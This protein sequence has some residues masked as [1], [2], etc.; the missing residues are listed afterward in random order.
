MF[1]VCRAGELANPTIERVKPMPR[2]IVLEVSHN[3]SACERRTVKSELEP[4]Y[5]AGARCT[6]GE[7]LP[8]AI[9]RGRGQPLALYHEDRLVDV[10]A[11]GRRLRD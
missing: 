5:A 7:V 10:S 8:L 2:R 11:R 9:R 3:H 1:G 4:L 6:A